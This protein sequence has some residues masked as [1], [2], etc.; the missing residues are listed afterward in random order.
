[1]PYFWESLSLISSLKPQKGSKLNDLEEK[2]RSYN[3][4]MKQKEENRKKFI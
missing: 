3:E 1:M 4:M 2:K